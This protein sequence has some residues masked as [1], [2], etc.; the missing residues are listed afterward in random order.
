MN[1]RI[2][3]VALFLGGFLWGQEDQSLN[4]KSFAP[5]SSPAF[6]LMDISSSS[7]IVPDNLQAFAI[8]TLAGYAGNT[9]GNTAGRNFAVEF[10]PYWYG[11]RT[12]MNFFK[13][14]NFKSTKADNAITNARDYNRY[15]VFGDIGKKASVSLA[16]MDG[17]FDVFDT[18]R[19]YVSV[20]ARTRLIKLMRRGDLQ[21]FKDNFEAYKNV[22]I[23][24]PDILTAIA[25]AEPGTT[26][27]VLY[28]ME[29]FTQVREALNQAVNKRPL[30]AVDAAVAYSHFLGTEEIYKDGDFGRFGFWLLTD[31]AFSISEDNKQYLHVYGVGRYIRDG[32]NVGPQPA[33]ADELPSLFITTA[34]DYGAKIELELNKVSFA[35]EYINRDK[36][37]SSSENRS[38][39]TFRYAI[40]DQFAITGG[41]GE[42]FES[43]GDTVTLFGIQ[44]GI[45]FGGSLAAPKINGI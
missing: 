17:T 15:D 2:L 24:D 4:L 9:N 28:S 3:F 39:G 33:A 26:L 29:K 32:L 8:Q 20:G 1:Y 16:L 27:D 41:F 30:L 19:S 38:F 25:N 5:P 12:N 18:P 31:L 35:Y 6:T 36:T 21:K 23:N 43:D 45:N 10:Q 34:Y 42:N 22:V 7:I 13:Y 37:G 11:E 40:N 14:N 44:W